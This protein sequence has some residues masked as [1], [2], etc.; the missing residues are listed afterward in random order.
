MGTIARFLEKIKSFTR[1]REFEDGCIV[2]LVLIAAFT[3]FF[4]GR[5]SI[6]SPITPVSRAED[7][8]RSNIPFKTTPE[9]KSA[10]EKPFLASKN[11]TKYYRNTCSGADRILEE[12]RVW[13]DTED[14]AIAKGYEKS[15]TC[16]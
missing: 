10:S 14:E 6:E 13:F 15:T 3:G 2:I 1:T 4:L 16:K 7:G 5:I 8:Q 9:A 11:G 12:N